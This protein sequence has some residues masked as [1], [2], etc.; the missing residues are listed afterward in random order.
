[1]K[2]WQALGKELNSYLKPETFPT[3]VKILQRKSEIPEGTRTPLK[4]LKVKMAHV[5]FPG[6]LLHA[7]KE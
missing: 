7:R 6:G 3:A 1:M 2:E 5:H 4:D